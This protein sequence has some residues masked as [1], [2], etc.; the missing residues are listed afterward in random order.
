MVKYNSRDKVALRWRRTK[1]VATFGP[2]SDSET[3]IKNLLQAGVDVVRINMSHSDHAGCEVTVKK[4]RKLAAQLDKP[5]AILMD[6]C[7][8]KIRVGAFING[9][10]LLEPGSSV[11]IAS[12]QEPG[13]NGRIPTQYT[14]LYKDVKKGERILLDD[15]NMELKITSVTNT[16]I[17]CNVIHGG[18]L[19][20]KKGIN[21]PDSNVSA[22]SFTEKDKKDAMLAIKLDIDFIALSFVRSAKDVQ[23]LNRFLEKNKSN[24]PVISKI[25]RPEAV[26]D[27]DAILDNSY[28]IMIARGDLGIELPA[29][30]V[31]MIQRDLIRKARSKHVPVIVATQMLE[32]MIQHSRP[33]RA[34]VN[35]VA[36]AAIISTDAVM[37]SA[38]TASGQFPQQ[39]VETMDRILRE[40]EN[41]RWREGSFTDDKEVVYDHDKHEVRTAVAMAALDLESNLEVHGIV[42]PT[43]SGQTARVI[44]AHRPLSPILGVCSG[45]STWQRL[46]LHWGV[47][48][49]YV[50]DSKVN[51]WNKLSQLL[52][53]KLQL[54]K[55]GNRVLF[56]SG[57][58]EDPRLAEPV[59][60]IV[61]L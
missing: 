56:V 16:D 17:H 18:I 43:S 12:S 38:E 9:E 37:L 6:L 7:G 58:N 11:T 55:T 29:E 41:H 19:K 15:G 40:I 8:P 39:A 61:S 21:L 4:I 24:I 3:C 47:I 25:E 27:I 14:K 32:S 44:S 28:G 34:E 33:T 20:D 48:P 53:K 54:G 23:Q 49:I 2:A 36:N 35:D 45:K 30:Q 42:V 60:K 13:Q 50:D 46:S 26:I 5:V 10:M 51:D 31:P 52:A 59:L 57:F 22:A 1:I